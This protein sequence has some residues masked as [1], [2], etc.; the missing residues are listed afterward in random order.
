MI[1]K[2]HDVLFRFGWRRPRDATVGDE[3]REDGF[4]P[5]ILPVDG[6][7]L[8]KSANWLCLAR[9]SPF[10]G[11]QGS[12]PAGDALFFLAELA[13]FDTPERFDETAWKP[14]V[15][16]LCLGGVAIN[17]PVPLVIDIWDLHRGL[18]GAA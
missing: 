12:R 4:P 9:M 2:A 17:C 8:W 7:R 16:F 5:I 18:T 11:R 14:I 6:G 1:H 3:S 13:L 15:V 10:F